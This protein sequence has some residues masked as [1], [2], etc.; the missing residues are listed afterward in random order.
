MSDPD[1][2]AECWAGGPVTLAWE[3]HLS[4]SVKVGEKCS[5]FL[6]TLRNDGKCMAEWAE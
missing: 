2:S 1:V 5:F 6:I 4:V 3:L